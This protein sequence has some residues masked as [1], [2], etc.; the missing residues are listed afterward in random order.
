MKAIVN[1]KYG[2]P[3]VLAVKEVA[4]PILSDRQVLVK[5]ESVSVNPADWHR[6]RG[7]PHF[8]RL[9]M[10]FPRPK[11]HV[12]GGDIA[13]TVVEVGALVSRFRPGD[14]VF[15]DTST[16]GFAEYAA[17]DEEVLAKKPEGIPF[18]S[19][20]AVPVAGLTALQGLRDHGEIQAGQKVLV[21]GASGGVGT[22]TVQIAKSYGAEV[23]C[24][25][26]TRNLDLLR[27]I[28]ADHVIDYTQADFTRLGERYDLLYD[29]VG[30][31]GLSDYKRCLKPSGVGVSVGYTNL[32]RLF[33]IQ[34]IGPLFSGLGSR[35][36][37]SF[38]AKAKAEDLETLAGLMASG[39]VKAVIDRR[40]DFERLPEAI[41][42]LEE[43]HARGKVVVD[44]NPV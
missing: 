34:A 1:Y 12:L 15:G 36:I 28:G 22:L 4:K 18:E 16:G 24:V 35:K 7:T 31:V 43:G 40:Y 3:A 14:K 42:Y 10:G 37:R 38:T 26:S 20:A 41:A 30:N 39:K 13:G 8:I 27:S 32:W 44:V 23:T 17:V 29:A 2:S 25:C 5:V 11:T 33:K 9:I 21:N 6:M 19:A